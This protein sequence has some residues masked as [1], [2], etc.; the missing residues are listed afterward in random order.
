MNTLQNW[1]F[2]MLKTHCSSQFETVVGMSVD[3]AMK[4][5]QRGDKAVL[6][7]IKKHGQTLW[8]QNPTACQTAAEW[9]Q[10]TFSGASAPAENQN[11]NPTKLERTQYNEL[12]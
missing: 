9:A 2:N 8:Q 5:C 7:K 10:L 3:D 1:A 4:A 6:K 11:T 12:Q